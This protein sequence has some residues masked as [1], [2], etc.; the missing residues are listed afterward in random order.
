[1]ILP[2]AS[3]VPPDCPTICPTWSVLGARGLQV[4]P[5]ISI[6]G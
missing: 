4:A 2:D 5:M 3:G 1:V 6:P